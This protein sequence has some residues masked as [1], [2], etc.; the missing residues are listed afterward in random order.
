MPRRTLGDFAAGHVVF[1]EGVA[2]GVIDVMGKNYL[3]G[4]ELM[5]A[6]FQSVPCGDGPPESLEQLWAP[7][8][9]GYQSEQRVEARQVACAFDGYL[10]QLT[11][12]T[13][14]LRTP[15]HG[16]LR[17]FGR[18]RT[19]LARYLA[20]NRRVLRESMASRASGD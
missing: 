16:G 4:W 20:A 5:R 9:A 17:A 7:Y 13:Y 11:T 18:W 15:L 3:P 6:F 10:Y 8:F 19:G 12:S 2:V 1:R 14:G